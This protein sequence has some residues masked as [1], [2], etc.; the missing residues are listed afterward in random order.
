MKNAARFLQPRRVIKCTDGENVR[1]LR[2]LDGNSKREAERKLGF[3]EFAWPQVPEA[4]AQ[5][6]LSSSQ[7]GPASSFSPERILRSK[8]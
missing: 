3:S 7:Q 6:W 2:L 8:P 5:Q 1:Y 4:S